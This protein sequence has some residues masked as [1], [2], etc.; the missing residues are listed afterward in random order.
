MAGLCRTRSRRIVALTAAAGAALASMR[1]VWATN[2]YNGSVNNSWD[3]SAN[4]SQGHKPLPADVATFPLAAP[5]TG[6]VIN[7]STGE[8]ADQLVFSNSYSLQGGDLTRGSA[9]ITV[10]GAP[11]GAPTDGF[12]FASTINSNL[13]GNAG[14]TK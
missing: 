3:T 5:L 9:N 13:L 4:W 7:L 12:G 1:P 2:D 6:R 10:D 14:I 11:V 8:T